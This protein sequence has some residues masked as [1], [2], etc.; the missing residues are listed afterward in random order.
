MIR[1]RGN[2]RAY[3]GHR[4]AVAVAVLNLRPA[5]RIRIIA[6][7]DLRKIAQHSEIKA[8]AARRAALEEN[9]RE[10]RGQLPHTAVKPE[11]IAVRRLPLPLCGKRL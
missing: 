2:V 6:R 1:A 5:E 10:T 3:D 8:V 11:Y 9:I 7:P 4:I